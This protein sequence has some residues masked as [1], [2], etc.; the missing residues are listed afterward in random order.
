[1]DVAWRSKQANDDVDYRVANIRAGCVYVTS[2][3]GSFGGEIVKGSQGRSPGVAGSGILVGTMSELDD[4][5]IYRPEHEGQDLQPR[6]HG[7]LLLVAG[8]LVVLASV[9]VGV[10]MTMRR[11]AGP[12]PEAAIPAERPAPVPEL[13]APRGELGP[14]VEPIDL[15][16]LDLTDPVV[17]NLLRHLSSRPELAAWLASDDLIRN[18]V[19]SVENVA[20]GQTPAR[21]LRGLKPSGAFQ[22]ESR[23]ETLAIDPRSYSRYDGLAD[24]LESMDA[25]NLARVYSLLK[26]RMRDA[27]R[28]LGHPEGD[29]DAATERAIVHL[30]QTPVLDGD[31]ELGQRALSYTFRA[32]ALERLS[33]AQKQLLRMGPRNVR[34][35]KARLRDIARELGIPQSSL[36]AADRE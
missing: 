34:I 33:P 21:H 13:A 30:L 19:A 36:P 24:T 23:G 11:D 22:A 3:V 26:P 6:R 7:R 27:Y 29:I 20:A 15:P 2:N 1:M 5:E 12:V 16:P 32:P 14:S 8:V 28:E 18:L 25:A 17:R 35:V 4:H 9:A 31:I 10:W